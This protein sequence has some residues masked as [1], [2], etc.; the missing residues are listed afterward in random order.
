MTLDQMNSSITLAHEAKTCEMIA[1]T[2]NT[3]QMS[4]ITA[5]FRVQHPG[6]DTPR[7]HNPHLLLAQQRNNIYVLCSK[8]KLK[9]QLLGATK[10]KI[11]KWVTSYT[12]I[13]LF[14]FKILVLKLSNTSLLQSI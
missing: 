1:G 3:E 6:E 2:G 13:S 7:K 9:F 11:L 4:L 12:C 14:S 10:Y 5:F 8:G